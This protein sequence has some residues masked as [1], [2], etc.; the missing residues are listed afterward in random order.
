MSD[1]GIN[2]LQGEILGTQGVLVQLLKYLR[3]TNRISELEVTQIIEDVLTVLETRQPDDEITA[4]AR[5]A[6]ERIGRRSRPDGG[7]TRST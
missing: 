6:V 2:I 5:K 1:R 4:A 7:R 3:H